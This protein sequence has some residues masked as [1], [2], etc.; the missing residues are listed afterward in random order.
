[1]KKYIFH[2]L[3]ALCAAGT[4]I[5]C[6]LDQFPESTLSDK[7]AWKTEDDVTKH[8]NGLLSKFRGAVGNA[9]N[10]SEAMSDLFSLTQ[11]ASVADRMQ[12]WTFTSTDLGEGTWG[13]NYTLIG[14]CN[15]LLNNVHRIDPS[16]AKDSLNY[17]RNR[18]DAIATAFL[19]RAFAYA[20]MVTRYC[21]NY[22]N[23]TQAAT[24]LGLPLVYTIDLDKKPS[25]ATLLDTYKQINTDIDSAEVHLKEGNIGAG[26]ISTPGLNMLHALRARVYLNQKRYD[27]AIAEANLLMSDFA[28]I[29]RNKPALSR[30]WAEDTDAGEIIFM[31]ILRLSKD[32]LYMNYGAFISWN[33]GVNE[34]KGGFNM[35]LIPTQGL[36]DLYQNGDHRKD[37][38]FSRAIVYTGTSKSDGMVYYFNKFPGRSDVKR[39]VNSN[40]VFYNASKAFRLAE[41]YLI[42]AEAN[43]FKSTPDETAAKKALTDLRYARGLSLAQAEFSSTGADLI[44]DMK[45]EWIREF[46]GEGFRID[47][48]K[49]WGDGFK[50][51]PYQQNAYTS[52]YN[53]LVTSNDV[54]TTEIKPDNPRFVWEIPTQDL[55]GN[56]NLRRNWS[57]N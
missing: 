24:A 25:R 17:I 36:L 30:M 23:E 14:A 13:G 3:M 34:G 10:T 7:D 22:E 29:H 5:S 26:D 21:V 55:M 57:S 8:Y 18:H 31:P 53:I 52:R 41:M 44:K 39:A 12:A 19:G 35:E 37:V 11:N 56:P 1:M 45:E 42:I 49:R 51:M 32:E 54:L 46:A 48:L 40:N 6:E 20:T 50:R 27:Q 16:T 15:Y 9:A 47:C 28:L 38:Y 2:A 33:E 4:M 43:L